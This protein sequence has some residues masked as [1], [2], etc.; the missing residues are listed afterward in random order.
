MYTYK[1][2]II[3]LVFAL[4]IGLQKFDNISVTYAQDRI[5]NPS[6]GKFVGDIFEKN[7]ATAGCHRG[8]YPK[9]KLNLEADKYEAALLNAFSRQIPTLKLV[10]RESPERSYLL[11]KMKGG[12]EIEGDIM[13]ID[14]PPLSQVEIVTIENWIRTSQGQ[15]DEK[16]ISVDIEKQVDNESNEPGFR[17]PPFWETRLVNLPTTKGIKKSDILFRVS[18]RFIPTIKTGYDTYYGINGPALILISLGYG[19]RDDL[20]VTVAHASGDHEWE[21]GLKYIPIQQYRGALNLPFSMAVHIGGSVVT[22]ERPGRERLD[23]E[24]M[25]FNS[26]LIL[27]HQLNDRVAFLLVPAFCT[28]TNHWVD[29][30]ESTF[31]LGLGGR[32]SFY[33][34]YS[35]IAEWIPVLDG[36]EAS[37]RGWGVGFEAKVGGHVFQVFLTNNFGLTTDQFIPGGDLD[38]GEN[39]YRIGFNIFRTF[40]F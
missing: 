5:Q 35:I 37:Q 13:P 10:D 26:Q 20:S 9:Q 38:I 29:D 16:T 17:T 27:S 34:N 33:R 3:I 40:W 31:A 8:E 18:H 30:S 4:L 24:N 23:S 1:F 21:L 32:Y 36:Y 12:P 22:E 7:C 28:N 2:T 6:L 39:E 15:V 14:G 11:M 25:K 19:I